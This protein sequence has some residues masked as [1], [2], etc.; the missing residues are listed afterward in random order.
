MRVHSPLGPTLARLRMAICKQ[1]GCGQLGTGAQFRPKISGGHS[2]E[3]PRVVF[4]A[5]SLSSITVAEGTRRWGELGLWECAVE[6]RKPQEQET[7]VGARGLSSVD[8]TPRY[9]TVH[10]KCVVYHVS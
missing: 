8:N 10:F 9:L 1:F 3:Q 2:P 7:L 5:R 4:V 6:V